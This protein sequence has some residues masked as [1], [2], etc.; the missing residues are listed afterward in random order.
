MPLRATLTT[1]LLLAAGT[2]TLVAA[3]HAPPPPAIRVVKSPSC[4]CCSAWVDYLKTKGFKV[5]VENREEFTALKRANGVTA[6][7]ESC[8]TAFINGYVVE[9]HVPAELITRLIE[10]KPAGVKG[11]AVPGMPVGSP[12]MEGGTPDRYTVF[13]FDAKGKATVFAKR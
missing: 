1:L 9:G 4:G 5:T 7:L 2:A 8:H 6:E 10:T 12:G 11:I 13:T 3:N